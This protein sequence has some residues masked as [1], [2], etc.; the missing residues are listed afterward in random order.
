MET[1]RL[2]VNYGVGQ[3]IQ[4][5]LEM[6]WVQLRRDNDRRRAQGPGDATAGVKW[7]FLGEEGRTIAW[8][9]Y[10]QVEFNTARSSVNEELVDAGPDV[11]LPT[12]ITLQVARVEIN[13]EVGR[14]F[15]KH[16]YGDWIGG[17]STEV[18]ASSRL[19]LLAELHAEATRRLPSQL[20]ANVG[21]RPKLTR[22]STLLL[23]AG[24]TVHSGRGTPGRVLVYAG[25]QL[26]LSTR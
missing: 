22:T 17:L 1:P 5:K 2:D 13:G 3:R 11:Q 23:A 18:R 19:E 21:A 7:R 15:I 12:Q 24:R 20:I 25:L 6:P 8:S 26:A 16:G 14:N 10:P 4:L 9:V